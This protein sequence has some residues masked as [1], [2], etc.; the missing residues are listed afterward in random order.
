MTT[1]VASSRSLRRW[2]AELAGVLSSASSMAWKTASR[3]YSQPSWL[4][5][6]SRFAIN[7]FLSVVALNS[8]SSELRVNPS[9]RK[10]P[11]VPAEKRISF[12]YADTAMRKS[13]IVGQL[14]KNRPRS[15]S[16][17]TAIIVGRTK[18]VRHPDE[19]SNGFTR[20]GEWITIFVSRSAGLC[21]CGTI[22][23]VRKEKTD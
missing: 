15:L 13:T 17:T 4:D 11:P 14:I 20:S 5:V 12:R 22:G 19:I 9:P 8:G 6:F 3:P 16:N 7:A 23:Q 21:Q 18:G 1:K 2:A 10:S